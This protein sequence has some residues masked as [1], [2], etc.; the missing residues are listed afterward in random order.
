MQAGKLDRRITLQRA[1]TTANSLNEPIQTWAAIATVWAAKMEVR[2]SERQ[3]AAETAAVIDTRFQIRWSSQ[4]SD[5]D[6][7]DRVVFGGRTFN[8]LGVKEIGRREGLELSCQAR[9]ETP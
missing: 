8:I 1:T 4:V 6:A 7:A 2:D 5:I 3:R 9:S